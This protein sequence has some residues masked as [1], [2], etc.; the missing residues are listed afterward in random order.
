ML[1]TSLPHRR[2]DGRGGGPGHDLRVE[3]LAAFGV[4]ASFR[5]RLAD[6]A[7][8]ANDD[9]GYGR[10][11]ETISEGAHVQYRARARLTAGE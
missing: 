7:L 8:G 5:H 11:A 6:F 9:D 2:T 10:V 1:E 4:R 3:V